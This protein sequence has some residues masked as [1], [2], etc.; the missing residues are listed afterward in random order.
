MVSLAFIPGYSSRVKAALAACHR[1]IVHSPHYLDLLK[2]FASRVTIIPEG[3][4]TDHFVP[5]PLEGQGVLMVGR[6]EY[7]AKGL[8]VLLRALD[9]LK[10]KG[11]A[12]TLR[13]TGS[14]DFGP[15]I[16]S[17]GWISHLQLPDL[18]RDAAVVVVPSVWEEPF[19]LVA[20]E[21]MA[22]GIPVIASNRGGLAHIV[23]DGETGLL[24]KAGDAHALAEKLQ[25]VLQDEHLRQRLGCAARARAEAL[26]RW[27]AIVHDYYLPL[28]NQDVGTG[29]RSKIPS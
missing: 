17:V 27:D 16:T 28:I 15:E 18:Y 29:G 2:G 11:V 26:C 9:I 22:C 14:G 10:E 6:V 24:F 25:L 23:K 19:G 8:S 12:T 3:V 4:N 21:A 7:P 13:V 5:S 1:H 20:A